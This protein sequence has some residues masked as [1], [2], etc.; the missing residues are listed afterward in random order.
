METVFKAIIPVEIDKSST[1]GE[2]KIRGLAS[3]SS[4]DQQGEVVL[5]EGLDISPIE[6]K[7][8][9]F[10]FDHKVGPENMVGLIDGGRKTP[11]GFFVE[12]RLFK[13]HD[14]AKALYQIM[15][16]LGKSDRGRV[17]MSVEGVIRE[18]AGQDGKIIKRAMIK[19]VALT[20]NPVNQDT[21]VDIAKSL[22]A[23][24]IDMEESFNLGVSEDLSNV[25]SEEVHKALGVS[26]AYATSTPAQ[27]EG[28]D[29]LAQESLD[30]KKKKKKKLKKMDATMAKSMIGTVLEKLQILYPDFSRT[31]LFELFK[32]RLNQ[33]FPD[34]TGSKEN[35]I[36]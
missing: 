21:Y 3:T 10:N 8:G 20:M 11:E 31:Q 27:L 33:R 17:G 23:E 24:G 25:L 9:Y 4:R 30:S 6:Q 26:S 16:S 2:W 34:L 1:E 28:G 29:A 35:K 7:K 14:K 18:R 22:N 19:A 12:G 5:Q 15:S 13:N 32:D 36:N